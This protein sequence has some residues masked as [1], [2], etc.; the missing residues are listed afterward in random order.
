M[1]DFTP[2]SGLAGGALIGLAAALLMLLTGRIAGVTGIVGGAL[3][4]DT[5]NRS[6]DRSA[7]RSWR[8]AFIAGLIGAPLIAALFGAPLPRPAMNASLV[9]V[10][11][12]GLL[13]GFGTRMGNGCTSGHG[14]CGFARLS[15]RS[16]V[17]TCIFMLTAIATVAIVRHGIGG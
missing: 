12:A 16:I 8:I 7:D 1:H 13:V 2:L 4:A 15:G 6:A 11:I 14:V 9:V 10:A 17:A 5:A 3:Q